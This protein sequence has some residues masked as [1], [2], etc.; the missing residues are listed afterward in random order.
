MC[1]TWLKEKCVA[2]SNLRL[3]RPYRARCHDRK[4]RGKAPIQPRARDTGQRNLPLGIRT[5]VRSNGCRFDRSSDSGSRPSAMEIC[6]MN[7]PNFPFGDFRSCSGMS[8]RFALRMW[9]NF[10]IYPRR[11]SPSSRD[12]KN[13]YPSPNQVHKRGRISSIK[14][15]VCD[16]ENAADDVEK[17]VS[18]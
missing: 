9:K 10:S 6:F 13:S 3:S 1:L 2:R 16:Q 18:S 11:E 15:R 5:N 7:R 8:F 17:L 12:G 14:D 4:R